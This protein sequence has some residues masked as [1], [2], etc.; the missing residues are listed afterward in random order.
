MGM[1]RCLPLTAAREMGTMGHPR[2]GSPCTSSF[3]PSARGQLQER[4]SAFVPP[5]K[6]SASALG[7]CRRAGQGA[8]CRSAPSSCRPAK[9]RTRSSS[10]VLSTPR[11]PSC[12]WG[13]VARSRVTRGGQH[14]AA[15]A[16]CPS[17]HPTW[18]HSLDRRQQRP[19]SIPPWFW[20]LLRQNVRNRCPS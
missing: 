8:G 5:C 4:L 12:G 18:E 6:P 13:T 3:I 20:G 10:P 14:Q 19:Q 11:G 1:L 7:S 2:R 9:R 15:P 17:A 16:R